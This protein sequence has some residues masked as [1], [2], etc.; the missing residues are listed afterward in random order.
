MHDYVIFLV[1]V[2]VFSK[3]MFSVRLNLCFDIRPLTSF[4]LLTYRNCHV[5]V[6][7]NAGSSRT[8]FAP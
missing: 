5:H 6:S 7:Q 2:V 3:L 4:S 8:S 1:V